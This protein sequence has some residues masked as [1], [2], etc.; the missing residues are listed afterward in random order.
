METF[1]KRTLYMPIVK[2]NKDSKFMGI[3]SD[4]SIDREGEII[5]EEAL[6][7]V[8]DTPGS[9][10]G[11][12]D[13][14]NKIMNQV[15]AWTDKRIEEIDGRV[16]LVAEPKFYDSNPNAKII[17]GMLEEGATVGVSIGAI[18][19]VA[20]DREIEGKK[21]KVY[22][23]MEMLEASFVAIP[24]NRH[25]MAM[26]VA[27]KLDIKKMEEIELSEVEELKKEL[28]EA[29]EKVEE[30]TKDAEADVEKSEEAPAEEAPEEAPAPEEEK[31][32]EPAEEAPAEKSVD[33]EIAKQ[34]EEMKKAHEDQMAEMR[35]KIEE[36]EASPLRKF[37]VEEK[38]EKKAEGLPVVHF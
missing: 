37:E 13:H 5:G 6:R 11:L 32:E 9:I 1:A 16:A 24:A 2:G 29:Q 10:P 30:L 36:L 8:A 27:K 14:E 18:P 28:T 26:A 23:D 34:M 3:L 25:A 19:R 17:K 4:N 33:E 20:E 21:V 31:K 22:T 7:R 38:A 12:M 15:C 35:K